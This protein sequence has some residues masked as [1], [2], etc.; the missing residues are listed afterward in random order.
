MWAGGFEPATQWSE[1]QHATAG[2]RNYAA[3]VMTGRSKCPYMTGVR[4]SQVSARHRCP[5]ITGVR[6]S[7]VSLHD[8]CPLVTGVRS[9]Q[10]STHHRC[11]LITGVHSSQVSARHRCPLVTGV[12]SSQVYF[13]VKEQIGPQKMQC[14]EI[15]RHSEIMSRDRTPFWDNVP[16]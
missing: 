5:L 10:V 2:P 4:S 13:N 14:P 3:Q 7:Q 12:R 15:G 6:S 8:R 16:R 9:S 1:V 11:P